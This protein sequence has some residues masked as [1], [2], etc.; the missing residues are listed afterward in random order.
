MNALIAAH[1]VNNGTPYPLTILYFSDSF[2]VYHGVQFESLQFIERACL[3]PLLPTVA[4]PDI[5]RTAGR[6]AGLAKA[7]F[8]RG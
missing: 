3:L 4:L 6:Q 8:A 7:G 2:P 1:P 5:A